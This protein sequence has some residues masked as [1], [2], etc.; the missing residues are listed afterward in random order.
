MEVRIDLRVLTLSAILTGCS[1]GTQGGGSPIVEQTRDWLAPFKERTECIWL[2]EQ[3]QNAGLLGLAMH[4]V[5]L[6]EPPEFTPRPFHSFPPYV[7]EYFADIDT[8]TLSQAL[9]TLWHQARLEE[10][11]RKQGPELDDAAA[12]LRR[13]LDGTDLVGFQEQFYGRFPYR[14]VAVPLANYVGGGLRGVGVANLEETYALCLPPPS[15]SFADDLVGLLVLVQHE[16]SHPVLDDIQ[17]LYSWVPAACSFVEEIHPPKGPFLGAYGDPE[18]RWAET[19]IRASSYFFL[20]SIGFEREAEEYV[21]GQIDRGVSAIRSFITALNPWW[22][23][24]MRDR[25]PGLDEVIHQLPEWL[26]EGV[27][28]NAV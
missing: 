3:F 8:V 10:L 9:R 19:M 17:R 18:F 26:S 6:G 20:R 13:S 16:A 22:E 7:K 4:G 12:R 2:R 28:R 23:Q 15:G 24:R 11:F 1:S 21:Q 5:Q 25:A 14:P 27:E